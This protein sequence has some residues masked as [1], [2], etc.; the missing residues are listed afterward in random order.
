MENEAWRV[1][2]FVKVFKTSV[3]DIQVNFVQM[4]ITNP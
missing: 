1:A 3:I 4:L 2:G